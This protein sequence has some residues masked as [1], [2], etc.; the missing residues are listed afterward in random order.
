[1]A[2]PYFEDFNPD[3]ERYNIIV[4]NAKRMAQFCL[5]TGVQPSEYRNLT[6]YEIEAFIATANERARKQA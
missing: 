5:A 6:Q 4:D 1:M 2:A 3:E